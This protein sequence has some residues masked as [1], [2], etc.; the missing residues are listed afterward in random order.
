MPTVLI[1]CIGTRG[2]VQPYV[3]LAT[4][5]MA[6]DASYRFV[7]GAHPEYEPFIRGHGLDFFPVS[8][9]IHDALHG[10]DAGRAIKN[11]GMFSMLARTRD[12]FRY[13]HGG[14][15]R[16]VAAA[17][18][19]HAPVD[20]VALPTLAALSGVLSYIHAKHPAAGIMML[21]TVAAY[22][23]AAF[24]PPT[25]NLG[26]SLPLGVLNKLV[27]SLSLP[28]V[29]SKLMHPVTVDLCAEHGIAPWPT[30]PLHTA[31]AINADW[32]IVH[33]YSAALLLKPDDWP[34]NHHVAGFLAYQPPAGRAALPDDIDAFV[35]RDSD[36]PLV[37]I[38]LGSMLGVAF[39]DPADALRIVRVLYDGLALA[40]GTTTATP[41]FRAILHTV[42][43]PG[44]AFNASDGLVSTPHCLVLET[45]VA[46]D[47]L[48]PHCAVV[49]HH[50]G[51]GTLQ[52]GLLAGCATVVVPCA[53]SSDQPFWASLVARRGCGL[54]AGW[55]KDLTPAKFA[56][57][58]A[59]ALDPKRL[60]AMHAQA[61]AIQTRMDE[62]DPAAFIYNEMEA[63]RR[64]RAIQP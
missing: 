10:S 46:H 39:D 58:L 28:L 63:V 54:D 21:H 13:M 56:G 48:F 22:P 2:D 50:G 16:S 41:R 7:L 45:P 59:Q 44:T 12:L 24:T 62:E 3:A 33:I 42:T 31:S 29:H 53:K 20:L 30:E 43:G 47:A 27:W 8:P 23:T 15:F 37:Y 35:K 9:S 6:R 64:K 38:G 19:A 52:T 40:Q 61:A 4:S 32:P 25:A 11:A 51:A 18:D 17:M 55:V 36:L 34:A 1:P 5:V 49:V 14:W 26:V 57:A 60:E